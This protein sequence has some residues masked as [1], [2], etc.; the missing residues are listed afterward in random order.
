MDLKAEAGVVPRETLL[1]YD[2]LTFL[3]L[4]I[5]GKLPPPPIMQTL[6][7]RLVAADQG[8]VRFEAEPQFKHYNPIGVVHG[9]F[10]MTML[11]SALGCAVHSTLEKGEAYTTLEFKINLVRPLTKNTGNVVAEGRIVHRGRTVATSEGEIKDEA[12]KLYAH[13]TTTCMVFPAKT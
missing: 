9:G 11:D 8:R 2:G 1:A 7:F 10:A 13:A 3:R 12:G 6:D 4:L 5:D